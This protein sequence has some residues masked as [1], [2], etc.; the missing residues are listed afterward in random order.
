MLQITDKGI[1]IDDFDT[2]YRRLVESFRVIYG[3]DVNLDSDTP[4]GQ[5]LGLFAQELT[6]IHQAVSFIVQM[7]DPYQATGN[8]LEQR[9][10]YAGVIRRRSSYSYVDDVILTGDPKTNIPVDSVFIDSNKNKWITLNRAELNELG[11]ARVKIRSELSGV[12]NLKKM[13]EL[14]QST[15]ILG[16][17]NIIANSASYGGADEETDAEL[18]R[19]FMVSHAINSQEDQIGIQ[20]KLSNLSGVE[21]CI[22][23]EN[24]TSEIDNKD[25]PSHSMNAVVLGGDH[26][27][28]IDILTEFKKGGCGFFGQVEGVTRYKDAT[29]KAYYDRPD[30]IDVSVSMTI[31]RYETFQD[32]D[33]ATIKE[34]LMSMNFGIGENVY[35]TRIISSINLTDGF[36]I[37]GLT[38]N[39]STLVNTGFR[40]Y[41]VINDVEVL[42]DE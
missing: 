13:D 17:K 3:Q 2:I 16:L 1:I 18:V 25:I 4:D 11:S 12:F 32:I 38:V 30:K 41:A 33:I 26:Q 5:L 27:E 8:W 15:V 28:I 36:Y 42:F 35:A 9:A 21:K 31:A 10:M 22:V 6:D 14:Q 19:R 39:G 7:L 40:E 20:A 34:N 37:T 24:F 29:R 23:Y